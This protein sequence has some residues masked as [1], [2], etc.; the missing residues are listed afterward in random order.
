MYT[1]VSFYT[2]SRSMK[3]RK[4]DADLS[5]KFHEKLRIMDDFLNIT[6]GLRLAHRRS[7]KEIKGH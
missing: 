4:N 1:S 3:K 7:W 6:Q 5:D 2:V